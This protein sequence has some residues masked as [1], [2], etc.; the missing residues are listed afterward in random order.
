MVGVACT[1]SG[2]PG[3]QRARVRCDRL[4]LH[5]HDLY[6]RVVPLDCHRDAGHQATAAGGHHHR[7]H[8]RALLDDLQAEGALP[9]HDVRV[10]VRV[11]E[12]RAGPL[13][14]GQGLGD[15]VLHAAAVQDDLRPVTPGG[16]YLG[17]RRASGHEHG[18]GAAEPPGG[19]RH[20]LR[21][22]ARA[23]RHDAAGPFGLREAGDPVVGPADLERPRPLQVLALEEHR[24]GHGLGQH[25]GVEQG[26]V[27]DHILDQL[28]GRGDILG[29][30]RA[31]CYLHETQVCHPAPPGRGH[32]ARHPQMRRHAISTYCRMV[33]QHSQ[34]HQRKHPSPCHP[35]RAAR[36]RPR[37]P[38][39]QGGDKA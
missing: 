7:A 17:Q 26:R 21:V 10:V 33:E 20:P 13:G 38:Q 12:H 11:D 39:C 6:L 31:W 19:E 5:A 27:R 9:G 16:L 22:V 24:P 1:A 25:A 29:A 30:D 37:V 34:H 23:G 8:R 2:P 14:E 15:G 28:A 18:G 3:R 35:R 32:G 36:Q 4:G